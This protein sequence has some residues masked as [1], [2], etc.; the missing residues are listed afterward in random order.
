MKKNRH[1]I[2]SRTES[3]VRQ[4]NFAFWGATR[5]LCLLENKLMEIENMPLY[6]YSNYL[7]QLAFCIEL[8]LKSIIINVNDFKHTH[9]LD[10]LFS[11]TPDVFQRKFKSLFPNDGTFESNMSNL[12]NIF[13]DFRYMKSDSVFNEYLDM[14]II[15]S[16][17][18]I[19]FKKA[20]DLLNFRFL[21]VFL[22]EIQEYEEFIRKEILKQM[23]NI[24]SS[25]VD[26]TM[27][28][29]TEL[30]KKNQQNIVLVPKEGSEQ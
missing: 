2:E 12:K 8:G 29:I 23:P 28:D 18:S 26:S 17:N 10:E 6:Q 1:Y 21:Q 22:E 27:Q 14:N 5:N 7:S 15:N 30:L 20:T 19:N 9:E 4:I 3:S 16:D 13:E 25:N 11:M 24:D